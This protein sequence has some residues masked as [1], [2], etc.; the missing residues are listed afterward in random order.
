MKIGTFNWLTSSDIGANSYNDV[1]TY[2]KERKWNIVVFFYAGGNIKLSEKILNEANIN[3]I[4]KKKYKLA[5]DIQKTGIDLP[6]ANKLGVEE[7]Q[8]MFF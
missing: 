3:D 2:I 4:D 7:P 1:L 8:V 6:V 5:I